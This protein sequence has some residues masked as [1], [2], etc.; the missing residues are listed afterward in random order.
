MNSNP[1]VFLLHNE[2]SPY[3]LPLFEKL[4]EEV[5]LTVYFCYSKSDYRRWETPLQEYGFR[6]IIGDN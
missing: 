3:R 2:I 1:K 5:D 6:S 4:A